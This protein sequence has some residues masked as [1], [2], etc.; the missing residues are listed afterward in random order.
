MR[1]IAKTGTYSVLHF[2]VAFSVALILTGSWRAAA[3]I[4]L[5]EPLIQ[6]AAYA[7]HERAWSPSFRWRVP[8]W[9]KVKAL[10]RSRDGSFT[11]TA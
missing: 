9:G 10:F 6:T 1:D 8:N 3:A 2:M 5:V 11:R 4:G 7:L